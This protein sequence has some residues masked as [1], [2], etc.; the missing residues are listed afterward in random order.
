MEIYPGETMKLYTSAGYQRS[1]FDNRS[2]SISISIQTCTIMVI[3]LWTPVFEQF[4][5]NGLADAHQIF[6]VDIESSW[7]SNGIKIDIATIFMI[8]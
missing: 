4:L 1:L 7:L 2:S 8:K 5:G 3:S 6:T